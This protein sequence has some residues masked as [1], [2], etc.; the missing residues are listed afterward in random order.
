MA[1]VIQKK[2]QYVM[3]TSD[4]PNRKVQGLP[5]LLLQALPVRV[6]GFSEKGTGLSLRNLQDMG[7]AYNLNP[8]T[9][10]PA[11]ERMILKIRKDEEADLRN[12]EKQ[13][14]LLES[15]APASEMI[16]FK[17]ATPSFDEMD[18][19][20]AKVKA[21]LSQILKSG[22]ASTAAHAYTPG[23]GPRFEKGLAYRPDQASSDETEEGWFPFSNS[24]S[25]SRR[26]AGDAEWEDSKSAKGNSESSVYGNNNL[27][28]TLARNSDAAGNLART[29][30]SGDTPSSA[31]DT[32]YD[33]ADNSNSASE[34]NDF[35]EIEPGS[36]DQARDSARGKK[37][38]IMESEY[39]GR[40]GP[41][42]YKLTRLERENGL[43]DSV[44]VRGTQ[45][46][47]EE[48][49]NLKN[50]DQ[51]ELINETTHIACILITSIRF[52][53][54][55]VC[56][57]GE[58]RKLDKEFI[59]QIQKRLFTFLRAN[60]EQVQERENL[61]LKIQEVQFTGWALEQADFLRKSVHNGNEVA[62]AFFPSVQVQ[63]Q[64]DDSASDKMVQ[65]HISDLKDD[66][67]VEFDLYIYMPE[68]NKYLLYTP[69]G[70]P[71]GGYQKSRLIEKGI[72]HMHLHREAAASVTKYKAQNF[73]NEKITNYKD[74]S[75]G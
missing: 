43:A 59:D 27:V 66:V 68:N 33:S 6:I 42:N 40:A 21:A 28:S 13:R 46:A 19:S 56:A 70:K 20:F 10:G 73:L 12:Y 75:K 50:V 51:P 8:P 57:M 71:L 45:T 29:S 53:G 63:A 1:Y 16:T 36:S 54:Y 38:P 23:A 39:V 52:S 7:L 65:L 69:K 47:L 34:S 55:L 49:V 74:R 61:S 5:K 24:E 17:G 72:T 18:P 22:E 44:F 58:N 62:M 9:S 15:G 35:P 2:P 60:G 32:P 25:D 3:I 11:I 14:A 4:H 41:K 31:N 37:V 26:Q 67:P 30:D 48:T 64:L